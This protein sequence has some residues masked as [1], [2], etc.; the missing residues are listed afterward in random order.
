MEK[1]ILNNI[2]YSVSVCSENKYK[3]LFSN[4]ISKPGQQ[5][6]KYHR[7]LLKGLSANTNF[8]VNVISKLP[9]NN[10][11]YKG[12]FLKKDYEKAGEVNFYYLPFLNLPILKN[13]FS[14]FY[15]LFYLLKKSNKNTV[16]IGDI[17]NITT[18]IANLITGKFKGVKTV[19]IVTDIPSYLISSNHIRRKNI[20][21]KFKN[22]FTAAFNEYLLQ[23]FD[24][25]VFL[26]E[27]MNTL[28]NLKNKPYIV[29]EGHVDVNM[30]LVQNNLEEKYDKKV[31]MYTGSLKSIYGI[32]MLTQAFINANVESSE[33]HIYGD[34][35]FKEELMLISK[36]NK[37]IK[38]LGVKL[39]EYI[40]KEQLKASL[41]INPRPT[42]QEYTKYSFPSKNMEYM[43]SGTP[44]LTTNLPGM[45]KEY[46][47]YVYL[48]EDETLGG[49]T[50]VLREV[51][52]K[53]KK[54]LYELGKKS[55]EFVLKE[56]NNIVQAA[57]IIE[58][59]KKMEES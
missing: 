36:E 29:L 51:L 5:S 1:K 38:Y 4:S 42:N 26:T 41:L 27:N 12:I 24:S 15:T 34:G 47:D 18:S 50:A 40:V 31:C 7:L 17:L 48:I 23:K 11:N 55:K 21:Y 58:M 43:V 57:K 45:P 44:T 49:L 46:R 33:L 10:K 20:L 13:I 37:N 39:N 25:Y 56:K 9:V 2:L 35:D 59:I 53:P 52:L 32:K 22:R 19:G 30:E 8:K 54:E 3:E 6:Q 14:F 28:I 16:I